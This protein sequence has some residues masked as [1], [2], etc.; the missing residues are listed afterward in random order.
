[1][2]N[3]TTFVQPLKGRQVAAW[4]RCLPSWKPRPKLSAQGFRAVG[5]AFERFAEMRFR[6]QRTTSRSRHGPPTCGAGIR[7]SYEADYL[8][9]YGNIERDDPIEF[10]ALQRDDVRPSAVSGNCGA[11]RAAGHRAGQSKASRLLRGPNDRDAG[12]SIAIVGTGFLGGPVRRSIES[13]FD[14]GRLAG[15]PFGNRQ[16]ARNPHLL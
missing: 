14:Y 8:R 10:Q 16:H 1:L 11:P 15:R 9:R 3:S 13:W 6:G 2:I 7:S 12:S 4:R 5:R